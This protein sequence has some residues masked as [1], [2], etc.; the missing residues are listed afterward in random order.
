M[1]HGQKNIKLCF[2][3]VEGI[4]YFVTN[5]MPFKDWNFKDVALS[6]ISAKCL[7]DKVVFVSW[8]CVF[9]YSVINKA[10]LAQKTKKLLI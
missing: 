9:P 8:Q 10:M 4:C 7:A 2:L 1:M 6:L 3:H 5:I